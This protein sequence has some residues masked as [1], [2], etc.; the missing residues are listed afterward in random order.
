MD[1]PL[2]EPPDSILRRLIDYHVTLDRELV[3]DSEIAK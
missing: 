3:M 1:A 2:D